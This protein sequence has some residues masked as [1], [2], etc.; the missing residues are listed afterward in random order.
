MNVLWSICCSSH[1]CLGLLSC[2]K[3]IICFSILSFAKSNRFFSTFAPYVVSPT[4]S[5]TLSSFNAPPTSAQL[6][7]GIFQMFATCSYSSLKG[8]TLQPV[9]IKSSM[10]SIKAV[11]T[12]RMTSG[13]SS[14]LSFMHV[15]D[16]NVISWFS[17][18]NKFAKISITLF[19]IVMMG[20]CVW[21][22]E[23]RVIYYN[24]K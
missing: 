14:I 9:E 23:E 18:L 2:W 15:N 1:W 13:S 10:D 24:L 17:M 7:V 4:S 11:E 3:L 12:P 16:K 8:G 20:C 22:F 19:H 5:L 21:N 6:C